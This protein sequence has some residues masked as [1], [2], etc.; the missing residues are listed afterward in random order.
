M[1]EMDQTG[2]PERVGLTAFPEVVYVPYP[3]VFSQ[4]RGS[5]RFTI[6]RRRNGPYLRR[7]FPHAATDRINRLRLVGTTC[8][9]SYS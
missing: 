9:A 5:W 1:A 8:R 3:A 4:V 6:L 7:T 2:N